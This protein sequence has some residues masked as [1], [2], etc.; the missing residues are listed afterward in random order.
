MHKGA[1]LLWILILFKRTG[2]IPAMQ[3]KILDYIFFFVAI[4]IIVFFSI[5]SYK[6]QKEPENVLINGSQSKW[7]YP[8]SRN[9]EFKVR[10]P[11]GFTTIEIKNSKVR[12]VESPCKEKICIQTGPISKTGSWIACVPN[13]IFIRIEGK[14]DQEAD[15]TSF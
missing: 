1:S 15:A 3:L 12:V 14:D 5:G 11:N 13:R 6:Q 2:T 8:L 4:T 7:I 10:G 9:S